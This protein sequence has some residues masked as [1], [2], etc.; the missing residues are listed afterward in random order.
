MEVNRQVWIKK[1]RSQ[2]KVDNDLWI[3]GTVIA[4]TV[5]GAGVTTILVRDKANQGRSF[6]LPKDA[7]SA[8]VYMKDD[9]DSVGD[10]GLS[11]RYLNEPE[12]LNSLKYRYSKGQ[13]YTYCGNVLIALK[14]GQ[15]QGV[16]GTG[17]GS[18]SG[19]GSA[20]AWTG[21]GV[22]DVGVVTGGTGEQLELFL[23]DV[24]SGGQGGQRGQSGGVQGLQYQQ[25][26]QNH[27]II[28]TG[29]SDSGKTETANLL[30][31]SLISG[32]SGGKGGEDKDDYMLGK[33][34]KQVSFFQLEKQGQYSEKGTTSNTSTV[35]MSPMSPVSPLS[36]LPLTELIKYATPILEAFGNA[37]TIHARN[38]TRFAKYCELSFGGSGDNGGGGELVGCRLEAFLLEHQRVVAQLPGERSFHVFYQLTA[39]ANRVERSR[40]SLLDESEYL[41][42][43]QGAQ[44]K[45]KSTTSG[46]KSGFT[47]LKTNFFRMGFDPT[48]QDAI[49]DVLAGILHLGQ[50]KITSK[51]GVASVARDRGGRERGDKD[52]RDKGDRER[53]EDMLSVSAR[54]L[55]LPV[56]VLAEAITTRRVEAGRDSFTRPLSAEQAVAAR[57]VLART[58]YHKLFHFLVNEINGKLRGAELVSMGTVG[59]VGT[60]GVRGKTV[61]I[62]DMFGFDYFSA[63]AVETLC[64]N[65]CIEAVQQ[66]FYREVFQRELQVYEAEALTPPLIVYR[67]NKEVLDLILDIFRILD[68]PKTPFTSLT[69]DGGG[70]ESTYPGNEL[71]ARLYAQLGDKK[72]FI[73]SPSDRL[74]GQFCVSHYTCGVPYCAS[75]SSSS[76]AQT[77]QKGGLE[78]LFAQSGTPILSQD[79]P[80]FVCCI[81]PNE[82]LHTL[83]EPGRMQATNA[84]KF[85]EDSVSAQLKKGAVFE[86]VK[87]AQSGMPHRLS[88]REFYRR[89]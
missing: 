32:M 48:A 26:Q 43:N 38:S 65:Y 33:S 56:A 54:L 67:D 78:E 66:F 34:E 52:G 49:F 5:D 28:M 1:E 72:R 19:S 74:E 47:R 31:G 27:S 82:C 37:R 20:G 14:P 53:G 6:R 22:G 41:Y 59:T 89:Y 45:A 25:N 81:S 15:S 42:I 69:K 79:T 58:A 50:I 61:G 8:E 83:G 23:A 63:H 85:H 17:A 77:S 84:L 35:D 76:F 18:W 71:A 11:L 39:G 46:D 29:I 60:V 86:V 36:G 30:I 68:D 3:T 4:K 21:S 70:G 57:D 16:W 51:E 24:V 87:L 13:L 9:N 12:I 10:I 7:D 75:Y 44:V 55:S 62:L 73:A 40:W 80:H 88:H 2:S 64:S